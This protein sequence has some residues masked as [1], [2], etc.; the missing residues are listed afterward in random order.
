MVLAVL[1]GEFQEADLEPVSLDAEHGLDHL[2]DININDV[3]G[4]AHNRAMLLV[5]ALQLEL[6]F[7]RPG[8]VEIPQPRPSWSRR[9]QPSIVVRRYGAW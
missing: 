3:G 6:G 1:L 5:E 7:A 8:M 2:G 4:D 9:N